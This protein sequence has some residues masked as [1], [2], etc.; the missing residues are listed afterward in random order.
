[1][2][3]LVLLARL[4]CYLSTVHLDT[5]VHSWVLQIQVLISRFHNSRVLEK[6]LHAGQYGELLPEEWANHRRVRQSLWI[7]ELLRNLKSKNHSFWGV[8]LISLQ[9][10]W[11]YDH[12]QLG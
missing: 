6:N 10:N 12:C 7:L 5:G 3:D 8:E 9:M 2:E 4:Q 11:I 1:M